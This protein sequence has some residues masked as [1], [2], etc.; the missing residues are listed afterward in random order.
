MVLAGVYAVGEFSGA[1]WLVIPQMVQYHGMANASG[2]ILGLIGWA[3]VNPK[4][5]GT[6]QV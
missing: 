2:L 5:V 3:I 6:K 4:P 1:G